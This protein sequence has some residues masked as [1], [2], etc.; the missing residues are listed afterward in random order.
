MMSKKL[1]KRFLAGALAFAVA[2]VGFTYVPKNAQAV[3][4]SP[5]KYQKVT[6]KDF[7]DKVGTIA[8]TYVPDDATDNTGYLFAGWYEIGDNDAVGDVIA[9]ADGITAEQVYAKSLLIW[10][11]LHVR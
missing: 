6:L 4:N 2:L 9:T 7:K 8:P 11:E 3:E 1:G 5:V 10:Q